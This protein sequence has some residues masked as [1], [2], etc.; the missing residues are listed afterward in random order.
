MS[1]AAGAG[2]RS[3]ATLTRPAMPAGPIGGP[4]AWRGEAMARTDEW[5]FRLSPGHVAE[6]DEALGR[7]TA[8]GLDVA[9]LR[10]EDFP[11]PSL[12]P[13]LDRI[14]REL[15]TGRGFVLLRGLPVE[16]YSLA[17]AATTYWGLGAYIGA[18]RSQ[19]AAGHLLGHVRDV[20][21]DADDPDARVYQTNRRQNYHTDSVDVVGLLCWRRAKAGGLS[22][23]VSSVTA[24]N[25]MRARR[26][27]LVGVMFEPFP[28][29]RR[30]EVPAGRQPYFCVPAFNWHEGLLSAIYVRRYIESSQRLPDAPRLSERQREAMDVFDA[31][32]EDR[33]LNLFMEFEPGDIQLLHNHQILHD[34]TAFEDWPEPARKRHLLRL[35]LCP[36]DGRP[37]PDCFTDRYGSVTVGDRGGIVVPGARLH[38]SLDV[39]G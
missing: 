32:L 8:R 14:R 22:S 37:L 25:E 19:N 11:L 9:R 5:I 38:V 12:G 29:D 6:V 3:G 26:P 18:A 17:E 4:S 23:I 10:R 33:D 34:R 35:W 21:R 1:T 31:I 28:T 24:Y 15:L 20:G 39:G 2:P 7:V 30:G 16:R 13:A 27:D 36:P